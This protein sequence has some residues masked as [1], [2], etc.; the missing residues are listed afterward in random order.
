MA[1]NRS[2]DS[3]SALMA[4]IGGRNTAPE[5]LVRRLLHRMGLRFRLHRRD[6]PGTPDIVLPRRR[7]V[8]FVHGCFWHGHGCK[9][10]QPPRSRPEFWVPKLNRTRERDAETECKLQALGWRVVTVWQCETRQEEALERRL[11]E[12]LGLPA[13]KNPIDTASASR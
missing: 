8:V 5:L 11:K 9:I 3:R 13:G 1:D 7:T 12:E 6:L 2:P 10:G 4:Q